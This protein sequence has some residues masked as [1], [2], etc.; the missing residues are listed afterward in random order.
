ME[1]IKK[2]S[3]THPENEAL[4]FNIKRMED[5]YDITQGR[6]DVA[7]RHDYYIVLLVKQASGKHIIDFNEFELSKNQMY[8]LSPGQ[9]HQ[10]IENEKSYG[11]ILTFSSQFLI[12]NGIEKCFIDDL[13]IFNDYGM[14]PP[15][16]LTDIE[17]E[18]FSLI[19]QEVYEFEVTNRKF[20]YQAIGAL[21]KLLLIQSNNVCSLSEDSNT[22]NTQ[23]S[24]SLLRNFKEL[25]ETNFE[26]WHM[27][28][29]YAEEL[30]I[31]PDYLNASLKSLTGTG[32]KEHIQNRI[33]IA[34]KRLLKFSDL[35]TKEISYQLGFSEPANFS[36]F[37][38]KHTG[39]SPSKF[40][41]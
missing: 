31:T 14:N 32:A 37:F 7:H 4:S 36:I 6:P 10:I 41:I 12:E 9:V 17:F 39:I 13:Y 16:Q 30:H 29:Q 8:F 28:S 33:L 11:H 35:N 5:V 2:Y 23:A 38:K 19:A 34:A 3:H 22:Q 27:V 18:K 26:S 25:L 21:L 20:K 15:L 40:E 1:L 24:V